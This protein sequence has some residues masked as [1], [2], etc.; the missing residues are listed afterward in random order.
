MCA[1]NISLSDN[2]LGSYTEDARRHACRS[3]FVCVC[4]CVRVRVRVLSCVIY[5]KTVTDWK[6]SRKSSNNKTDENSLHLHFYKRD[7]DERLIFANVSSRIWHSEERA[8][9]YIRKIEANKMHC[10]SALADS[11]H[12]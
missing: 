10:L 7:E 6:S 11:Q 4:V 2:Y 1:Q 12:K 3:L 8:S 5:S 9:W